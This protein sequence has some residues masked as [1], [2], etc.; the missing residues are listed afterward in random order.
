MYKLN[1]NFFFKTNNRWFRY[2]L[3]LLITFSFLFNTSALFAQN[4]DGSQNL[5]SMQVISQ[6]LLDSNSDLEDNELPESD[7]TTKIY[8]STDN[9]NE[10]LGSDE[11]EL[12]PTLDADVINKE[13]LI[14]QHS[15]SKRKIIH[16]KETK[17]EP[18]I[19]Q[20][21]NNYWLPWVLFAFIL[22]LLTVLI[23]VIKRVKI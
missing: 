15:N 11:S 5:D 4:L 13:D 10:N 14:N 8:R 2:I 6:D 20:S 3:L 23:K 1:Y 18:A 16:R 21:S 22:G 19:K 12:D 7:I 17:D 9:S